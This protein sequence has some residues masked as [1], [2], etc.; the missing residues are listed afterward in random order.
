LGWVEKR[1]LITGGAGFIGSNLAHRLV[2]AGAKVRVLD[3]LFPDGGGMIANLAGAEVEFA[4]VDLRHDPLDEY[5]DGIEVLFNLAAQTGHMQ[6]QW[7]PIEDLEINALAQLKLI[8]AVRRAA[9]EAVVVHGSTRQ[10]YGRP[11]RV[12]VDETHP[13]NPPD[14]NAVSKLAG[15]TYWKLEHDVHARRVVCLRLTNTYGPRQRIVDANQN[16]LGRWFGQILRGETLEVWG[17]QQ[18]RDLAHVDDVV[19]ALIAAAVCDQCVGKVY[20]VGGAPP[21]KL[22]DLAEKLSALTGATYR[23]MSFP[24]ENSLIDVGSFYADDEA[25][26]STTNWYPRWTLDEGLRSTFE[27]FRARA[28][29]YLTP[30]RS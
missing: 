18:Y 9:P 20:N 1:V 11:T 8:E 14:A 13:L 24:Q 26:R 15:E 30:P 22:V 19:S 5:L 27:W 3:N 2:A 4:Q 16:F 28:D 12:P 25:F 17:G 10:V 7:R 6:A 23:L 21:I 29:V